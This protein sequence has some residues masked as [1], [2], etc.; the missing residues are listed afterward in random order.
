FHDRHSVKNKESIGVGDFVLVYDSTLDNSPKKFDYRWNGPYIVRKVGSHNQ[1]Y[2]MEVDG[3]ELR[4]PF[5]RNR[6]KKLKRRSKFTDVEPIV[7][8]VGFGDEGQGGSSSCH[9]QDWFSEEIWIP[10]HVVR[11]VTIE[12]GCNIIYLS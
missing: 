6:V 4:E 5:T 3:S 8:K 2:L 7:N 11:G 10:K 12:G 9:E 1:L